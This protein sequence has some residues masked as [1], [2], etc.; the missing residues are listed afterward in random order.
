[1]FWREQDQDCV[2]CG[3]KIG[4][5][6]LF[7]DGAV[8]VDHILPRWRS[9][10]NS[11][12]NQVVCH[13]K[14][15]AAKGEH[16]PREW[17]EELDPERYERVLRVVEKLPYNKRRRFQQ[18]DIVLDH[19][20]ERQLRDT[21]YISRRVTEYL[22]CLGVPIICSRGQLTAELRHWWGLDTILDAEGRG[23]KNRADHRHHA[24]DAIAI[25]L[26][27]SKR[28][29]ALANARGRNMPVPWVDFREDAE[30]VVHGINV[31][32][33]AQRRLHGALHEATF[34]GA[35]QKQRRQARALP[36]VGRPWAKD[37]IE[38]NHV[39][40]RRKPITELTNTK[41]LEKV[42]DKAIRDILRQ[43]L[44]NLGVDPDTPGRIPGHAFKGQNEPRM[45]SGVPIKRVRMI[46]KSKTFQRV[47][48]KRSYQY[49]NPGSNH[50]VV[51]RAV[52]EGAREKWVAEVITMWKAAI[53]D[54]SGTAVIDRSD[55]DKGR[56][57][58]SLSIGEMFQIDGADGQ[59]R[60]CVVQKI[61]QVSKRLNY[62][63]HTDARSTDEVKRDNLY[64]SPKKMQECNAR[65]VTVDPLGRIRRAND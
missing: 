64:L 25:A 4:L 52:G 10:D 18:K 39:Y 15:N 62:K 2:Y 31:S 24:I 50:Y 63:S 19:F 34:Y 16:T 11:L 29:H 42:R 45:P 53:C 43:R 23:Q 56:F 7:T 35:T 48:D 12:P 41:H 37:W 17:L 21:A 54:R 51:Y 13:R 3:Q 61:D 60:L 1:M 47:S 40:V 36:V 8:D 46:E 26:T 30:H 59:R 38:N 20:V 14:C 27:D 65:K 49:V 33:R 32:H 28:L 9:L 22:R 5:A 58:M 57:V 55:H 44:R 6:Q